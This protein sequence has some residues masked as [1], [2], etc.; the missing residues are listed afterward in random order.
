[1]VAGSSPVQTAKIKIL[2]PTVHD[3]RGFFLKKEDK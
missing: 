3:C 2:T 1:V